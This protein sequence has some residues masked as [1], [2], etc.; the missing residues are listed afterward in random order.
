MLGITIYGNTLLRQEFD[1][2]WF[3]PSDSYMAEYV[4][5]RQINYPGTGYPG[6]ELQTNST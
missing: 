4:D 5:K 2:M 6:K 1:P 3:L